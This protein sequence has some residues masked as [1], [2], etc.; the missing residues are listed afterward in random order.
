VSEGRRRVL[1]VDDDRDILD[2]LEVALNMQDLDVVTADCGANAVEVARRGG[3]DV[4]ITDLKMPGMSGLET[5]AA[6][7][8]IQPSLPVIV[9]TG[10]ASGGTVRE[11]TRLGA[12]GFIR[13]PFKLEELFAIVG[14]ALDGAPPS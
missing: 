4:A 2:T 13:K 5:L 9:V 8:R 14:R 3:L 6:L 1:V 10:F 7:K 11:C 12:F